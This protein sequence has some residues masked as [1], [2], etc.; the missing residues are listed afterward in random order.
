MAFYAIEIATVPGFGFV[1]GPEFMT[2][3]QSTASGRE[4]RNA[5]WAVCRHKYTAPF[6]NI[7]T[8]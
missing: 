7:T 1:G 8:E 4:S 2:N 5:D 6:S 3:V